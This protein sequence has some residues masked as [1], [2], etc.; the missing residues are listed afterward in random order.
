MSRFNCHGSALYCLD[1]HFNIKLVDNFLFDDRRQRE[2]KLGT[3]VWIR[4]HPKGK[5]NSRVKVI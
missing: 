2:N 3:A 4:N 1:F 5:G